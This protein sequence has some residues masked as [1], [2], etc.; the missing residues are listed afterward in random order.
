MSSSYHAE[1][2]TLVHH[3]G[4]FPVSE[5]VLIAWEVDL[6]GDRSHA[7]MSGWTGVA[8]YAGAELLVMFEGAPPRYQTLRLSIDG[9]VDAAVVV[10][11]IRATADGSYEFVLTG[12]GPKPWQD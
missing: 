8:K 3:G 5:V 12:I 6:P 10:S 11:D 9:D 4:E 2:A 7:L 1:R